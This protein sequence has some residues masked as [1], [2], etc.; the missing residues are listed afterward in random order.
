MTIS[1]FLF[2]LLTG[3][4]VFLSNC[5]PEPEP[6]DPCEGKSLPA[7]NFILAEKLEGEERYFETDKIIYTWDLYLRGP[8]GYDEYLWQV[9][10]N[11]NW[12]TEKNAKVGFSQPEGVLKVRLIAKRKPMTDCF[13]NDDGIDTIEKF[14]E[15]IDKVDNNNNWN[16][17]LTGY[18]EGKSTQFGD[19]IYTI[20]FYAIDSAGNGSQNGSLDFYFYNILKT[21]C[22]TN[23]YFDSPGYIMWKGLGRRSGCVFDYIAYT[24][25]ENKNDIVVEYKIPGPNNTRVSHTF[26]GKRK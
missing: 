5:K 10:T 6:S 25:P 7:A 12:S 3:C 16:S 13:P 22:G 18:W 19:T 8:D 2:I 11:P 21:G 4:L 20:R 14:I 24:T 23:D 26:K 9:G 17:A 1:R 15:V